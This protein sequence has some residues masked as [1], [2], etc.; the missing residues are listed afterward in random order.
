[1][2]AEPGALGRHVSSGVTAGSLS[3]ALRHLPF[4]RQALVLPRECDGG[5]MAAQCGV[6][7]SFALGNAIATASRWCSRVGFMI[8]Q[9][10]SK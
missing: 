8:R 2:A 6:F 5:C 7:V 9:H 4:L 10:E 3:A 1:M